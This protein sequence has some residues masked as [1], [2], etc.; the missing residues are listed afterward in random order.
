MHDLCYHIIKMYLTIL[1]F[2]TVNKGRK[3]CFFLIKSLQ[4]LVSSLSRYACA[5]HDYPLNGH[6]RD[7]GAMMLVI[8]QQEDLRLFLLHSMDCEE[9]MSFFLSSLLILIL[10]TTLVLPLVSWEHTD[11]WSGEDDGSNMIFRVR[12]EP[13]ER[14]M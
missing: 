6:A 7:S 2:D 12:Y 8:E 10:R 4:C 1:S 14:C 11:D 5:H 9:T 13:K 3:L